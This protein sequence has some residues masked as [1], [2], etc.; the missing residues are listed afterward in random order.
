[1]LRRDHK[2]MRSLTPSVTRRGLVVIDRGSAR[3]LSGRPAR[4]MRDPLWPTVHKYSQI[5]EMH[6]SVFVFSLKSSHYLSFFGGRSLS[7][8]RIRASV[9]PEER[10]QRPF[11]IFAARNLRPAQCAYDNTASSSD[12]C[13]QAG[14]RT[15]ESSSAAEHEGFAAIHNNTQQ[16]ATK[17]N[18]FGK[19]FGPPLY[20]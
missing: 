9:E 12:L 1:M 11:L 15:P 7:F 10:S 16:Y 18:I 3:P 4:K 20:P 17:H 8:C 2:S 14:N 13:H 19:N 5:N 6:F